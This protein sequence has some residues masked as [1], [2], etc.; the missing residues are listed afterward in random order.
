MKTK[1]VNQF[2][3]RLI[4]SINLALFHW[5]NSGFISAN[6]TEWNHWSQIRLIDS[7]MESEDSQDK[8]DWM[9]SEIKLG[10][11]LASK[12]DGANNWS[13]KWNEGWSWMS[14]QSSKLRKKD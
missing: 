5:L 11:G 13:R 12:K 9:N 1:C 10:I 8:I 3:F 2:Q 7:G 4:K 6:E 14:D